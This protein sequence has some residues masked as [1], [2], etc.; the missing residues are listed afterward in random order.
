MI[1]RFF[2]KK[3]DRN[4]PCSLCV[5]GRVS[6]LCQW[7]TVPLGRP[8]PARLPINVLWELESIQTDQSIEI[9]ELKLRVRTLE[10]ELEKTREQYS[11]RSAILGSPLSS[12]IGTSSIF[13]L[14]QLTD[15]VSTGNHYQWTCRYN[16]Y[17]GGNPFIST[18]WYI[19]WNGSSAG[20]NVN[21]SPWW[22]WGSRICALHSVSQITGYNRPGGLP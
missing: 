18:G 10:K 1:L 11:S 14:R 3:C 19:S 21:C 22:I 6:H 17:S 7:E 15:T 9:E 4:H 5:T 16:I 12:D 8:T 2:V 13:F 20:P